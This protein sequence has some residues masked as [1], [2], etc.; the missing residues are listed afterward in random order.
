M[1]H[2]LAGRTALTGRA[3]LTWRGVA[4][5]AAALAVVIAAGLWWIFSGDGTRTVTA[6]FD[7]A[8]GVY[9]GTDV[10]VLGVRVGRVESVTPGGDRVEVVLRLDGAAPVPAD[11]KAVVI[12]PSVVADRYVQFTGGSAGAEPITD[13]AVIPIERTATPV[14]L[15]ELY[16]SLNDLL[17]ALGPRGANTDGS[18]SRLLDTGAANLDGNG[19]AFHETVRNFAEL[20]RTLAG[21]DG[22][23]FATVDQLQQFTSMLAANDRQVASANQQLAQVSQTLAA[24]RDEL[25][26]ALAGLGTALADIQ[27]FISD[28]RAALQSNVDKLAQVTQLLVDQRASLAE[29]LD[30]APLAASN[31]LDSFDPQSQTLQSRVDLLEYLVSSANGAAAPPPAVPLPLP[32]VPGGR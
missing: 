10:R 1:R 4:A 18:L 7:R 29:A 21:S 28:N 13:G 6:Y 3:G 17:T 23:L 27:G 11:T 20:A 31:V 15:D 26:A 22:D 24:D 25:A 2:R 8:V 30:V 16:R 19:R 5:L 32:A 9:P 14:E 12:A